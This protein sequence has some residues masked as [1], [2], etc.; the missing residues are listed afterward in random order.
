[1]K[2]I[3]SFLLPVALLVSAGCSG[4]DV[5]KPTAGPQQTVIVHLDPKSTPGGKLSAEVVMPL[6]E[7]LSVAVNKGGL[8]KVDGNEF[9]IDGSEGSIVILTSDSEQV[10]KVIEPILQAS[11]LG[12]NSRVELRAGEKDSTTRE[13]SVET[14]TP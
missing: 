6:E 9:K 1:M 10:F 5:S 14:K 7:E 13:I 3:T 2:P 8:G 11:P 12:R 4:P